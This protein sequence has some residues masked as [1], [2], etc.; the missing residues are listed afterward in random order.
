MPRPPRPWFR[1][2]VE[3]LHDPKLRR[4]PASHRWVWVAV[5]AA[6]RASCVPGVLMVSEMQ[7]MDEHDLADIAA[8]P[9][10]E[11]RKALG[12]MEA[13]G[14]VARAD[15][16]TLSVPK[17]R[18]RQFESDDTT[19]RTRKH[20][21]NEHRRNVPTTAV[22]TF[23]PHAGARDALA[24]ESETETE[25]PLPPLV[26]HEGPVDNPAGAGIIDQALELAARRYGEHR[27]ANGN[28]DS[29]PGLARWWTKENADDAKARA[30]TLL[31]EYDLGPA[32]LAD[33][34]LEPNPRWLSQYRRRAPA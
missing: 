13:A 12:A 7:P 24:T 32:Q 27:I 6:A 5:L 22:G 28:G 16:G 21:S 4:M 29:A 26:T 17:W 19:E 25:P 8:V 11:V 20:R 31:E 33:A 2:Y 9:M 1:L 3:A 30:H 34:L 15:D 10:R 18:D 23:P 14:M